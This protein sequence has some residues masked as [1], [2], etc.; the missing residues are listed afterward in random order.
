MRNDVHQAHEQAAASGSC[1]RSRGA[2]GSA[3]RRRAR[4]SVPVAQPSAR[5]AA[6]ARASN[7][8]IPRRSRKRKR[9]LGE[10]RSCTRDLSSERESARIYGCALFSRSM[11]YSP[12]LRYPAD[13][14]FCLSSS[15]CCSDSSLQHRY[16][17]SSN[18]THSRVR[19]GNIAPQSIDRSHVRIVI[20]GRKKFPGGTFQ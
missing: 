1:S 16:L 10:I 17:P 20:H 8:A 2:M 14:L 13:L 5:R 6:V 4:Q 7:K 18:S 9:R 19:E 15:I 12:P 3:V 11:R